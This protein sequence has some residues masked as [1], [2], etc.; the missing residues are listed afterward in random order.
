MQEI[1]IAQLLQG[2]ATQNQYIFNFVLMNLIFVVGY[3][4]RD[5]RIPVYFTWFLILVFLLYA[6]W[7]TDYFSFR[8]SFHTSLEGHRDPLYYYIGLLSFNSY[9]IFR[10]YIWGGALLLATKTAQ[11]LHIN[12]NTYAFVFSVFFLLI[13]SYA[14]V[15]LGMAM[16]FYGLSYLL[17]PNK[18]NTIASYIW[19]VIFIVCS[20]FGH[21]SMIL[22]ILFTPLIFLKFNKYTIAV[23]LAVGFVIGRFTGEY[24]SIIATNGMTMGPQELI[25]AT[26]ALEAYAVKDAVVD[27]NWKYTLTQNLKNL[28]LII[29]YVYLIWKCF[30]SK[31]R[32]ILA[33]WCRRLLNVCTGIFVVAISF[34]LVDGLGAGII[35]YRFLYMI[36]VPMVLIISYLYCNKLCRPR[37]LY[38]ILLSIFLFSEG[39]IFGK[40]LSF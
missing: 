6:F 37:T 5:K 24:L 21:R 29:A 17:V 39:F 36:G 20:Y 22:P 13:F 11:R 2:E 23:L 33:D 15:S 1:D 28:G 4:N 19:G 27:Y 34:L 8:H 16:Y 12:S 38:F 7:D 14:R 35:G 10:F 9:T 26:E 30:V 25:G 18:K 40:I 3:F 31:S 32:G